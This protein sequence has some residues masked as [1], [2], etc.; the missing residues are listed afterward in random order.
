M[1]VVLKVVHNG[2]PMMVGKV[3]SIEYQ[4]GSREDIF[5]HSDSGT[6]QHFLLNSPGGVDQCVVDYLSRIGVKQI[7]HHSGGNVLYV[8]TLEDLIEYGIKGSYG[9]R[10]RL[11]LHERFW[12]KQGHHPWFPIPHVTPELVLNHDKAEVTN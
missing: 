2:R 3:F 1:Q 9:G 4:N 10:R 12:D 8:A 11:Y 6:Q 7:F 5:F